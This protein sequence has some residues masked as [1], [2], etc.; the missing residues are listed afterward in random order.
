VLGLVTDIKHRTRSMECGDAVTSGVSESSCATLL[1]N[2]SDVQRLRRVPQIQS[3]P[4][5]G[6]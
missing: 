2:S 4:Q 5:I 1:T 6:F 3:G